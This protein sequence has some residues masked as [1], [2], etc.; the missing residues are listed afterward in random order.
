MA[1]VTTLA[2]S[3]EIPFVLTVQQTTRT[4]GASSTPTLH[5]RDALNAARSSAA[6]SSGYSHIAKWP[7]RSTSLK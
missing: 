1:R 6:N 7:P 4:L 3:P 5:Y 2:S